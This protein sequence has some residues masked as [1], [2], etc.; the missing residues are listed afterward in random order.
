MGSLWTGYNL[1]GGANLK[2]A[3]TP[4]VGVVFGQRTGVA[5][6]L[7]GSLSYKRLSFYSS[8]EYVFDVKNRD[9]NFFY[10][11]PQLTFAPVNWLRVGI[12][13]QHTKVYNT[14]LSTDYG[15]EI[16]VSHKRFYFTSYILNPHNPIVILELGAS[17]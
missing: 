13:A 5:P 1:S 6:G 16:S 12:A 14:K 8:A 10:A 2:W 17:F 7:E 4:M 11:W 3:L 15:P 9:N